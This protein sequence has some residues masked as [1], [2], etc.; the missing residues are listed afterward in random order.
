[1][2]RGDPFSGTAS[3]YY[4]HLTTLFQLID[5]GDASIGLPP[6]NG[7]LFAKETAPLLD[8]VHLPDGLR[9]LDRVVGDADDAVA[10]AGGASHLR[11]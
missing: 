11:L 10:V 7:G 9:V 1:M 2:E 8:E 4:N 3:A 6:Y 5:K